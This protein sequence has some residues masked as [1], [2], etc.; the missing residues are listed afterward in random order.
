MEQSMN[1]LQ[2]KNNKK[3]LHVGIGHFWI[4]KRDGVN[5]VIMRN[6]ESLLKLYPEI[7][8]T[9]FG[10]LGGNWEE[11]A[12]SIPDN[13]TY[14]NIEEFDPDYAVP[15]MG[16][17]SI[18]EQKIQDYIWQ[19]TNIME[20]LTKKLRPFDVVLAENL[21]I[22][23]HPSV[24]YAFYL[25]LKYC[26]QH[27]PRKRIF[28]R[29]HDFL[30]QRAKNFENLKKFQDTEIP[31]IPNWHEVIYPNYP[32]LGYITINKSDI[33]RLIEHGIDRERVAYVPNCIDEGLLIDDDQHKNLRT[34]MLGEFGLEPD[35]RFILYPV[36]CVPRKNVEEAIFLTCLLNKVS[37]NEMELQ[38]AR[39]NGKFHLLVGIKPDSGEDLDYAEQI[40]L[41]C[42][43]NNLPATIGIQNLVS[44]ERESDA[45]G[46]GFVRYAIGDA[47]NMSD[48]VITTSYLEGFGFAFIEPWYLGKAVIGRAIPNITQDF[49]RAGVNLDHLYNVL[50][51][52]GNDFL[53]IG[54]QDKTN[55]GLE[56]RLREILKLN[57]L[58][59]VRKLIEAN[60][61]SVQSMMM[62]L[63]PE[64]AQSII[65]RNRDVVASTYSP[66]KV[67]EQL[68]DVLTSLPLRPSR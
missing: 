40:E 1:T 41:F 60:E 68:L 10:K 49:H 17:K 12:K 4:G 48:I 55:I 33:S 16:G 30:Q 66:S 32:N 65:N 45:T 20:I 67:A 8:V 7:K 26:Q 51:I 50:R 37:Q 14:I 47:Y 15:G 24:T 59:Y 43:R 2:K 56:K 38:G 57:D 63:N 54:Y 42:R 58:S 28:Y 53:S 62:F 64:R 39:I 22:G 31:L 61:H 27:H 9:L 36:R 6:V 23:I 44:F 5:V 21:G 3:P 13:I 18:S 19:G 35:V 29:A 11:F 25:Y 34:R 52:N 46:A